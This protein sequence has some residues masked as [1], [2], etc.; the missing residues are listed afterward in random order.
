MCSTAQSYLSTQT[1]RYQLYKC[2]TCKVQAV[3]TAFSVSVCLCV[4]LLVSVYL[5]ECVSVCLCE[6]VSV[7]LCEHVCVCVSLH[8]LQS[9][10]WF[11]HLLMDKQSLFSPLVFLVSFLS[12]LMCLH[13]V[14]QRILRLLKWHISEGLTS[15]II[16]CHCSLKVLCNGEYGLSVL[17][18][19]MNDVYNISHNFKTWF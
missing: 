11:S 13:Y 15:E 16:L 10:L 3:F 7:Y 1:Y 19:K 5:C 8:T 12:L 17:Y 14:I 18:C 4:Y 9:P 2:Q 6:W